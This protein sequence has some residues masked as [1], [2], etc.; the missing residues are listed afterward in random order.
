M[1]AYDYYTE[2]TTINRDAIITS[3]ACNVQVGYQAEKSFSKALESKLTAAGWKKQSD[4]SYTNATNS[5]TISVSGSRVTLSFLQV[6]AETDYQTA[7]VPD[8][9]TVAPESGNY[10]DTEAKPAD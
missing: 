2:T 7:P 8:Y 4:N 1:K 9:E 5:Y 6:A 10:D 3:V